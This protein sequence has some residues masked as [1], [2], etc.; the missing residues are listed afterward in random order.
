[1]DHHLIGE[2]GLV[3]SA[4]NS[5]VINLTKSGYN[6]GGARWAMKGKMMLWF[7]DRDGMKNH[8]SWGASRDVYGMYFTQDAYDRF[9]LSEV[10]YKLLKEREDKDKDKAKD[11]KADD[12]SKL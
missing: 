2:V 8:G 5:E 12:K 9:R 4:G 3:S 6:D 10:D 1:M 7:S 11:D